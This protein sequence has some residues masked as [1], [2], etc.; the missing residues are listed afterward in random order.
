[1]G[2]TRIREKGKIKLSRMFQKLEKGDRVVIVSAPSIP[3]YFSGRIQGRT[4]RIEGKKGNSY[5]IRAKD[6]KKEK[7][8]I[9]QPIHLKKLK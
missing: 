1:M 5:I 4:G 8:F 9:V 7:T 3:A 2:K 6:G